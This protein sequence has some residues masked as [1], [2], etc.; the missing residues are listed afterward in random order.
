MNLS[1]GSWRP[2]TQL[3][4]ALTAGPAAAT[5]HNYLYDE[6]QK[7]V[8]QHLA[9]NYDMIVVQA[10]RGLPSMMIAAAHGVSREAIDRRLRPLGLKNPPGVRGRPKSILRPVV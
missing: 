1:L 5:H 8:V 3:G 4:S 6:E 10:L 7:Q 9:Q 2:N